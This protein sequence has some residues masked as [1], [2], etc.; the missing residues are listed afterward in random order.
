MV[1]APRILGVL[2]SAA[3]VIAA[4]RHADRASTFAGASV[5]AVFPPLG[6]TNAPDVE[7]FFPAAAQ[8]GHAGPTPSTLFSYARL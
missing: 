8:V 5:S 3:S 1:I 6:A 7:T 4:V 2:C